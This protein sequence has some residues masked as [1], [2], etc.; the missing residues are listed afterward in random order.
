MHDFVWH[1]EDNVEEI[2]SNVFALLVDGW[3]SDDTQY[4]CAFSIFPGENDR[5]FKYPFVAISQSSDKKSLDIVEHYA[6]LNFALHI[7][8]KS[9]DNVICV[10]AGKCLFKKKK[11]DCRVVKGTA[12]WLC[13]SSF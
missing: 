8:K 12:S 13:Q 3:T 4:V 6:F 2:I 1:V 9:M 11:K 7:F 5:G 10:T